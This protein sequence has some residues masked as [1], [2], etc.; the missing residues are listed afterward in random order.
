ML[1]AKHQFEKRGTWL[2]IM[3][4]FIPSSRT[5]TITVAGLLHMPFWKFAVA[6]VA[7]TL[8]TAP[9]QLGL[10]YLIGRGIGTEST[11]EL[12][13]RIIGLIM[14]I[15]AVTVVLGWWLQHRAARGRA[16]RAKAAWLRRFRPRRRRR[17]SPAPPGAE[18]PAAGTGTPVDPEREGRAG[19]TIPTS[20][21]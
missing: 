12:L 11:A 8:V 1:Q 15:V 16:P 5:T 7:C 18:I 13:L 6:T 17:S 19:G 10:G 3:A 2:I 14:L 4:R 20:T 21:R 9:M